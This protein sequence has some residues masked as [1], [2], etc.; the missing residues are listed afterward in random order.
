MDVVELLSVMPKHEVLWDTKRHSQVAQKLAWALV[1]QDPVLANDIR[2]HKLSWSD[3]LKRY[4]K[5]Y[6]F[7]SVLP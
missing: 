5:V 3:V 2:D 4:K 7:L 1:A 6:T